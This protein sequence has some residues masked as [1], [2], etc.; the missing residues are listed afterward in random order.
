MLDQKGKQFPFQLMKYVVL[1]LFA[2]IDNSY[3]VAMQHNIANYIRNKGSIYGA[4]SIHVQ[5]KEN[6]IQS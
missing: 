3:E 5:H 1:V 2:A 6:K 4:K